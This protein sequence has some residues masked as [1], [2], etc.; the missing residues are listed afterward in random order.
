MVADPALL[1][2]I[3]GTTFPSVYWPFSHHSLDRFHKGVGLEGT[4]EA[5]FPLE[6]ISHRDPLDS[7]CERGF[8]VKK[9]RSAQN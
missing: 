6:E 3:L 2:I 8:S 1:Y 7:R 9:S 5:A 4:I